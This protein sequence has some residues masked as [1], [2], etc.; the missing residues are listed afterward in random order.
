MTVIY[1]PNKYG[2]PQ[3][4]AMECPLECFPKT[5]AI[6]VRRPDDSTFDMTLPTEECF[7]DGSFVARKYSGISIPKIVKALQTRGIEFKG[8]ISTYEN[9][10]EVR[11]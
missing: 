11:G 6:V 4:N 9:S 5:F 7:M 8:I 2:N 10:I 3:F 1:A